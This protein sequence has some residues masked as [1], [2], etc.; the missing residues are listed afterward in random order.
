VS[1]APTPSKRR[2]ATVF[3]TTNATSSVSAI[4]IGTVTGIPRTRLEAKSFSASV[5]VVGVPPDTWMT[6]PY[7]SAF[8]PSVVTI[9]VMPTRLTRN[10]VSEPAASA[11]PN[12][13]IRASG[14]FPES[15][16]GCAVM[17]TTV[18]EIIPGTER[19][20]PPCWITS[21]CPTATMARIAANGSIPRS[22][23]S[24]TLWGS[25]IQLIRKSP[26]VATTM[27]V[28]APAE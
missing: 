19:S 23:L 14:S 15:P 4:A 2:P 11:A 10:P 18:S 8:I 27:P 12:A 22:E 16:A 7:S 3:L 9:G 28:A 17:I 6:V 21:V 1:L 25:T 24:R 5:V 13:R 26:T 20:M